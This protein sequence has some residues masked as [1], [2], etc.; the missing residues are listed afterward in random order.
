MSE[1]KTFTLPKKERLWRKKLTAQL[2]QGHSY[3]KKE[4]PVRVV[5]QVVKRNGAEDSPVEMM[6]SVSK[7]YF[8]RAVKR[9]LIKRQLRESYRLHKAGLVNTLAEQPDAKLLIAFI[10]LSKDILESQKVELSMA[11][12]LEKVVKA[13]EETSFC[14]VTEK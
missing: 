3:Y 7:R 5:Y 10:W 8:K 12:A 11:K 9:N 4:W 1:Q 6:V 2:F 13:L 14:S